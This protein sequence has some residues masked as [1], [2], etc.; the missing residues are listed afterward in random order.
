MDNQEVIIEFRL[1]IIVK[2]IKALNFEFKAY[3]IKL[4]D[5]FAM[6]TSPEAL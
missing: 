5:V 3:S 6:S 1:L 2:I 4:I